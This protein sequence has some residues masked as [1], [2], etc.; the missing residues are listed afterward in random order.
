MQEME[1]ELRDLD[2]LEREYIENNRR[3]R[4]AVNEALNIAELV[5]RIS[6]ERDKLS[7]AIDA[8]EVTCESLVAENE[9]LNNKLYLAQK[10]AMKLL[11]ISGEKP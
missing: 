9:M 4:E 2:E 6:E 3:L 5:K 10:E 7:H 8:K 1:E 11:I